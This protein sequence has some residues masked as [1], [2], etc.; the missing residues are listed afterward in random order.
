MPLY[1]QKYCCR[2]KRSA[3]SIN[4]L[5]SC[6]PSI[7]S[8]SSFASLIGA[9]NAALKQLAILHRARAQRYV[10]IKTIKRLKSEAYLTS[11]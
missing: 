7:S 4:A 9:P 1:R 10:L 3:K 5:L 8:P 11:S 2:A 6:R